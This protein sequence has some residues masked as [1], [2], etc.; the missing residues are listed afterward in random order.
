L[1]EEVVVQFGRVFLVVTGDPILT[2]VVVGV[3]VIPIFFLA[4][5]EGE[6]VV[7]NVV[8]PSFGVEV[9]IIGDFVV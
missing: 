6:V 4:V 9:D 1:I 2:E 8:L 5:V 3:V 7:S